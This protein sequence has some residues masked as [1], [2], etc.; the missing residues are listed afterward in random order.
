MNITLVSYNVRNNTTPLPK[1]DQT[2]KK[3]AS[4][5]V[6]KTIAIV[7]TMV[8]V[9][10]TY[11]LVDT[12]LARVLALETLAHGTGPLGYIGIFLNGADP[13][14]GGVDFGSS[15]GYGSAEFMENSR[16][17]FH[18]FRDSTF[19]ARFTVLSLPYRIGTPKLHSILSGMATFNRC[20]IAESYKQIASLVGG[21]FGALTPI[22]KFRYTL[23]EVMQC[24]HSFC[25]EDDPNYRGWAYRTPNVMSASR[26]GITGSL[27]HG[28]DSQIIDRMAADPVKVISGVGLLVLAAVTA[29]KTYQYIKRERNEPSE[30][31]EELQKPSFFQKFKRIAIK[32]IEASP[33]IFVV[34]TV[35]VSLFALNADNGLLGAALSKS[36]EVA[37][38]LIASALTQPESLVK[39]G[40]S[41]LAMAA[42]RRTYRNL[43]QQP[44]AAEQKANGKFTKILKASLKHSSRAIFAIMVIALNTL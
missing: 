3:N 22:L 26:L 7:K 23:E 9:W 28:I 33:E 44:L 16:N 29:R 6:S 37:S 35:A 43:M 4:S 12:G 41:M 31:P 11:N 27:L 38:H 20:S 25:L 15:A 36:Q 39:V 32:A 19:D 40:F 5:V 34:M 18:V 8:G 42:T 17:F 10:S 21:I 13:N 1:A 14:Y 30:R 2:A 24:T